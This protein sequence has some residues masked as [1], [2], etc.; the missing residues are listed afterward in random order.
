MSANLNS[1]TA[2][3]VYSFEKSFIENLLTFKEPNKRI[4]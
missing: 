4:C 1:T 3:N 2:A